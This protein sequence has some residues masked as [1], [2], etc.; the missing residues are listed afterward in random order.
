MS[1]RLKAWLMVLVLGLVLPVAGAPLRYCLCAQAIAAAG[2]ACCCCEDDPACDC[3]S[4][5]PHAPTQPTCSVV[6]KLLPDAVPH[7]DLAVPTPLVFDLPSAGFATARVLPQA[8]PVRARI[9][10]RG[11]PGPPRYLRHCAMLL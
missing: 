10:D 11:P 2:E 7:C 8:S 3:H 6:L 4:E 5:C 9:H 1:R